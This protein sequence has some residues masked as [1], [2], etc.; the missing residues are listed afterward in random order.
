MKRR[1]AR[2]CRTGGV[3]T[4]ACGHG[5]HWARFIFFGMLFCLCSCREFSSATPRPVGTQTSTPTHRNTIVGSETP[6][7]LILDPREE[8]L[9]QSLRQ[10]KWIQ[11]R[12]L[13]D[14]VLRK[15]PHAILA[16]Y[17]I[18]LV[19]HLEEGNLP[20]ALYHIQ[21]AITALEKRFGST[22][23]DA[24][25][26]HWHRRFLQQA[27]SLLGEMDRREDQLRVIDRY[28]SLYRPPLEQQRV[29]ALMK[30]GRYTEATRLAERVAQS[31][32]VATR[33]S[34]LNGLIAIQS[35][36]LR[37]HEA[38]RE[39]M[40]ALNLTANQSCILL[41]NTAEAAFAV[42]RFD[43][44]EQL[45]FASLKAKYQDCPIPSY[46][47]LVS[48]YLVR[49]DF[50]RAMAAIRA[51]RSQSVENRLRQQFEANAAL[52][53]L[54]LLYALGRYK[55]AMEYGHR[56]VT[57]PDRMGLTS[58]SEET[59]QLIGM[60]DAYASLSAYREILRERLSIR[61]VWKRHR[62][63]LKQVKVTW[64]AFVLRHAALRWLQKPNLLPQL[65]RPYMKP[66]L[67]WNTGILIDILG[68][69]VFLN[70]IQSAQVL[71]QRF[72]PES[73]PKT[74][75][76]IDSARNS[77]SEEIP[78]QFEKNTVGYFD[79]F[80]GEAAFR[81]SNCPSAFKH[82]TAALQHLPT[83]EVLLRLR[84]MA[85]GGM[86]AYRV[87]AYAQAIPWLHEVLEQLP[88]A[89]RMLGIAIPV[90]LH[91]EDTPQA[92]AVVQMLIRSVRFFI[93][94]NNTPTVT[95]LRVSASKKDVHL[96]LES[97]RGRQYGC[98]SKPLNRLQHTQQRIRLIDRFVRIVFSP[99]VDLTQQDLHGLDGAAVRGDVDD[100]LKRVRP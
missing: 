99:K 100:L 82:A 15:H 20:Q 22:P 84:T 56:I 60:I 46:A 5:I 78:A 34:G 42:Y 21:I 65:F 2:V 37:P 66:F 26:Q 91:A 31:S 59:I 27:E 85:W 74:G 24:E 3:N 18:S 81:Q 77:M 98:V 58:F 30:L 73:G 45:V 76:Q 17:G 19:H 39:G 41:S 48:L 38:F 64:E 79:A 23:K 55:Q 40:R 7:A 52:N 1:Q 51:S 94:K 13:A 8:A 35:E 70:G 90:E 29:W 43:L 11:T 62:L 25:I 16:R 49:G 61:P 87:G 33:V 92:R 89:F 75:P 93:S 96:C 4:Q 69:G 95:V 10:S 86:C 71:T 63:K 9:L 6:N 57:S 53:L 80:R 47:H 83:S 14:S 32:D 68:S 72:R 88:N 36:A 67:P 54:R 50:Q 12:E 44:V 28:D 97:A